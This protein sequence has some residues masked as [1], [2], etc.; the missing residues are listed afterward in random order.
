MR[1]PHLFIINEAGLKN[2]R[3]AFEDKFESIQLGTQSGRLKDGRLFIYRVKSHDWLERLRG[4]R[5]SSY[6]T[7][8]M[9]PLTTFE[10]S[11][12]QAMMQ[13]S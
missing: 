13:I 10:V 9:V 4:I 2:F 7:V 12:L 1:R 3:T 6:E 8:G 5:I 11:A